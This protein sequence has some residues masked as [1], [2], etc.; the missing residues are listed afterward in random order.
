MTKPSIGIITGSTR[1]GRI[2]GDIAQWA[3]DVASKRD[4]ATYTLIDIATFDLPILDEPDFAA[5]GNYAHDHTKAWSAAI[6][7]HDGY[8]FVTPEYNHSTSGALKNAID[9]L[10][11]EWADKAAGFVGYGYTDGARAVEH[12]RLIMA[13]FR[14]AT[15][16]SQVG[17]N[18]GADVN[19]GAFQPREFQAGALGGTLDQ[20]TSWSTALATTRS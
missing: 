9:F 14:V 5:T 1:P 11:N 18:L 16:R 17:I 12:L 15:V 6:A 3:Y 4:D 10:Y 8:L 20:L 7:P 2:G 19:E 13:N